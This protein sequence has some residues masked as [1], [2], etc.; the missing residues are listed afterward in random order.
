MVFDH[1]KKETLLRLGLVGMPVKHS[2]SPAIQRLFLREAGLAGSY[3]LVPAEP[4]DLP[5]VLQALRNGDF[6][7]LNVTMPHKKTVFRACDRTT[8]EAERTGA[9]NAVK[10]ENGRL[11]GHNTDVEAFSAA[12]FGLPEPFAVIGGGGAAMAVISALGERKHRVFLR[13][14]LAPGSS[15]LAEA[16][17]FLAGGRG[18]VVNATPLGWGNDDPFPVTPPRGWVFM[19]LNYNPGWKW[20]NR[21]SKAGVEVRTGEGMLVRQGA[22]SFRFWT[23]NQIPERVVEMALEE[24]GRILC[25]DKR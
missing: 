23:G 14:P 24:I 10:G 8:P 4:W 13:N 7:G 22:L 20:R 12:S 6:D 5:R 9:V 19:D 11:I 21:L 3:S 18:T 1:Q 2:L 15:A 16:R 25:G 17:G